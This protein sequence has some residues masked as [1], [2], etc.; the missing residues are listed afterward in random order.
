[1]TEIKQKLRPFMTPNFVSVEMPPR[2]RQEGLVEAPKFAL[3][4]LDAETLSEL[5]DEF[6]ADVFRKANKTDPRRPL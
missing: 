6:R 1:M 5:C 4:E 2:P 3:A